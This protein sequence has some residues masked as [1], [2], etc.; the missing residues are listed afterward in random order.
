M[1]RSLLLITA[2]TA[3]AFAGVAQAA[4]DGSLSS[5]S[6][7]GTLDVNVT[8]PEMVRISGLSDVTFNITVAAITSP[9]S[10]IV[11]TSDY[12]VYSN[13]TTAGLYDISVSGAASGDNANPFQL[14]DGSNTLNH[15]VFV[16]DDPINSPFAG[17]AHV[18]QIKHYSTIAGGLARPTDINCG[19]IAGGVN[20][21]V[22]IVLRK[23]QILAA[24]AGTYTGTVTLTVAVP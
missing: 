1:K 4:T 24:P 6:S 16:Q 18:N 2:A 3:M 12:C 5:S 23:A 15:V 8:I 20:S 21:R 7:V 19:N 10:N 9:S 14:V 17:Y 11:E 22:K 13:V